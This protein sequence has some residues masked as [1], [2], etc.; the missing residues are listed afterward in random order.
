MLDKRDMNNQQKAELI[1]RQFSTARGR[2]AL[3]QAHWDPMGL[4]RSRQIQPVDAV[5]D[6]YVPP[7]LG[8]VEVWCEEI[9]EVA[10]AGQTGLVD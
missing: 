2:T 9:L 3:M 6:N 10:A 5:S 8:I 7:P 4:T 1:A